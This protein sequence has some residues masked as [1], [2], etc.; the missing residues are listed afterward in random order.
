MTLRER[1]TALRELMD[2]PHCDPRRLDATL[3]RFGTVNRLISGWGGIYRTHLRPHLAGLGRPARVLDLG[4]GGGDLVGRLAGLARR[5]GLQVQW[6]GVDPDPRAHAVARTRELDDVQFR[7]TDSTALR[8]E[9][10]RFDAV[11]SN[12]V[13]HHLTPEELSG[14]AADSLALS[15]GPV[16]HADIARG[17]LAYG[18][19][20]VG[21][22]PFAPGTFL[23]TDGLRSIRRSYRPDELQL[24]LSVTG[25]AVDGGGAAVGGAAHAPASA[26]FWHVDS[27]APFRLLARG[28]GHA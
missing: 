14:F 19:Y 20:A 28:S 10:E 13:L 2:D 17:R 1:D 15:T 7:S 11:V 26:H 25:D 3:R 24:A 23:H 8:A 16:L 12:H 22:A 4:C 6:L 5:D 18:L 27:P 9:G 21:I